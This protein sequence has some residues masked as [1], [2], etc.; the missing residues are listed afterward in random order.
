M[1]KINAL[2]PT[3][4][5]P[6][7]LLPELSLL[8]AIRYN[9]RIN[10]YQR[11]C[12]MLV[13][14]HQITKFYG[15]QD[16][17]RQTG[18]HILPGEK[19][20]LVGQNGSGKSTLLKMV[21]GEVEPDEGEIHRARHMRIGYLPQDILV[22]RGKNVIRQVLDVADETRALEREMRELEKALEAAPQGGREREEAAHR[23]AHLVDRY[24]FLGGYE[25]RPRAE[26]ILLGLG[27]VP[28]DFERPVDTLSGGWAM[29]VALARLLLADPDLLL[30]DEPTNH[31]DLEALG[32]LEEYLVQSSSSVLL[33]SHDR[34]FVNRVADR[35]VD[36]EDG[37]LISHEGNYDAYRQ[38]KREREAHRWA[39]YRTQQEQIR[40]T[41][42]FIERNRARKDRA[43]QVQSRIKALEKIERIE[44]PP[45]PD[46]VKFRFP[47]APSSGKLV[48]H[49][50]GIT[51]SFDG[52]PLYQS[53][54]LALHRG[55]RVAVI[56]ANG[57]GKSTLLKMLAGALIPDRGTRRLGHGVKPAYFAQH[58]M[59]L[60]HP[61]KTVLEEVADVAAVPH[62]GDLRNLLGAFQ[63]RGDAVFKRVKV[64]S[65]GERSR[66][67]LC[68]T[69]LQGGNLLLLDEPTNHLDIQTREVLETALQDYDGTLCLVTHDRRFMNAVANHILVMRPKGWELFPGNYDDFLATWERKAR[70]ASAATVPPDRGSRKDRELKRKEAEWRNK[71]YRLRAP[72]ESAIEEAEREAESATK[73]LEAL[74]AELAEPELYRSSD[75]VRT[76]Q[77]EHQQVKQRL[78]Q[79]T[80]RWEDLLAELEAL[81]GEM[82]KERPG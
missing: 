76:L 28:R 48:A 46:E 26:K 52:R 9:E 16:L 82:E 21:L 37:E 55:D 17:F 30:L 20:A 33:I 41:E 67:L 40:Q 50:E 49:L 25:L 32:W 8:G 79:W 70:P 34:V 13:A 1:T 60:L 57:T 61:G 43:R 77:I 38:A 62:Q 11:S 23:L 81:E 36:I 54:S 68:K 63:F 5:G 45:A 4:T 72:I 39:A 74:E 53:A 71:F 44:L 69:L 80:E 58:Q 6:A 78:A 64:L 35:I 10:R 56:G 47:S 24:Q 29:R 15:K 7:L 2:S 19:V 65:G 66:L 31:L 3:L 75:R 18:F 73:Q 12:V 22:F 27:F 51:H 14:A 59:E 42:R